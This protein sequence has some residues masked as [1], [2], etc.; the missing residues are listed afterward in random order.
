M[1][2]I[3]QKQT[4]ASL[5]M[6][7]HAA[8][9][10]I[11]NQAINR[12]NIDTWEAAHRDAIAAGDLEC[13]ALA[14][15]RLDAAKERQL[16]IR[17]NIIEL[18]NLFNQV[19]NLYDQLPREVWLRALNV[20]ESEWDT[21][22]MRKYGY[23]IRHVVSALG[24]VAL[25][26]LDELQAHVLDGVLTGQRRQLHELGQ[27]SLG[28]V[29]VVAQGCVFV[30]RFTKVQDAPLAGRWYSPGNP[31]TGRLFFMIRSLLRVPVGLGLLGRADTH[32]RYV[33]CAVDLGL[34]EAVQAELEAVLLQPQS[35]L[36]RVFVPGKLDQL[37]RAEY[38]IHGCTPL[39]FSSRN[40]SYISIED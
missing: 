38:K 14:K 20:N 29:E 21:P 8:R 17:F 22:D 4:L 35:L 27:C 32:L 31:D 11:Q 2:P 1:T 13:E 40:F 3:E 37:V 9:R 24:Q 28:T 36:T 15:I 30:L 19:S 16:E 26:L 39:R 23:S 12:E 18:G 7:R 25:L 34:V 6:L 5:V 10:Q 33:M